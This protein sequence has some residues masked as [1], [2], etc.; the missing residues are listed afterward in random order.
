MGTGTTTLTNTN[1][2]LTRVVVFFLMTKNAY[3]LD[4]ELSSKNVLGLSPF[5]ERQK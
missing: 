4:G 1:M 3:K 2:N 5:S